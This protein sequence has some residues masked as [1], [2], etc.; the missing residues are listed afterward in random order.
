[1]LCVYCVCAVCVC[2]VCTV[3]VLSVST[4]TQIGDTYNCDE[5]GI[6]YKDLVALGSD[7]TGLVT[8]YRVS[9]EKLSK[10]ANIHLT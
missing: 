8:A 2:C 1:M 4:P 9:S 6:L 7:G 10:A 3:C 5:Y